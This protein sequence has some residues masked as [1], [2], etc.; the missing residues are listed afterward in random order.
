[1]TKLTITRDGETFGD[2]QLG[3]AIVRIGR[4]DQND[5]VLPDPTKAVSRFHAELRCEDGV[6]T[7]V[8]LNSQNGT[9]LEGRQVG[10]EVLQPGVVVNVGPYALALLVEDDPP[11]APA[12]ESA[13]PS[14]P[15]IEAV[16]VPE[17]PS[18]LPG[19]FETARAAFVSGDYPAAT[20]GLEAIL[21]ANPRFPNAA[22]L[23]VLARGAS[24]AAAQLALDTGRKAEAGGDP[25]TA[26]MFF[27]R[28]LELDPGSAA[29]AEAA[30]GIQGRRSGSR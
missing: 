15:A 18:P 19:E 17:S 21:Q 9:W 8:D 2:V 14:E 25:V 29:A 30:G 27:C 22:E 20:A 7:L 4:G 13:A 24:K 26:S 11:P 5:V 16:A 6:Y 10:C 1:M 23:L 3:G 12:P 28:A